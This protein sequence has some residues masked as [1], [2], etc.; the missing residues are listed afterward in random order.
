MVIWETERDK[1]V[2]GMEGIQQ[3]RRERSSVSWQLSTKTI[4][5]DVHGCVCVCACVC[6][7]VHLYV[8]VRSSLSQETTQSTWL[9]EP[10][11]LE[12]G[13]SVS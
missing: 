1:K 7:Q 13:H 10:H 6:S 4:K 12:S 11:T 5:R 9:E 3:R 2:G 8:F